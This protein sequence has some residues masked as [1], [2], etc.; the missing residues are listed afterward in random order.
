MGKELLRSCSAPGLTFCI[1]NGFSINKTLSPKAPSSSKSVGFTP[2]D[3]PIPGLPG[4]ADQRQRAPSLPHRSS[5]GG[6][7]SLVSLEQWHFV[8]HDL[9]RLCVIHDTD[10]SS[11]SPDSS[12]QTPFPPFLSLFLQ[13]WWCC[14]LLWCSILPFLGEWSSERAHSLVHSSSPV[15]VV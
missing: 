11:N 10:S 12:T 7:N 14:V 13:P 5:L 1:L 3:S 2:F 15:S 9:G 6:K 8:L 4:R